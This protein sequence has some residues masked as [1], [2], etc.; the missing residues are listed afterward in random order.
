MENNQRIK[1]HATELASTAHE[2]STAPKLGGALFVLAS[3][4]SNN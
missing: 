1:W 3:I 2:N 4:F